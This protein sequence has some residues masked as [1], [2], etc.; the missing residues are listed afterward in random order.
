M[1]V[2]FMVIRSIFLQVGIFYGHFVWYVVIRYISPRFGMWQQEKS[3]NPGLGPSWPSREGTSFSVESWLEKSRY[4]VHRRAR[5]KNIVC[6]INNP[7]AAKYAQLEAG[8]ARFLRAYALYFG[9]VFCGLE[10]ITE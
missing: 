5:A 7:L 2:Y 8:R 1:L 3:G 9:L 10:N 4:F 6:L